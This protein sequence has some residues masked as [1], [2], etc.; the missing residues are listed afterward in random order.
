MDKGNN[1]APKTDRITNMYIAG[2][3]GEPR[4]GQSHRVLLK[5]QIPTCS[6][7]VNKVRLG[8]IVLYSFES[9]YKSLKNVSLQYPLY[10]H[11]VNVDEMSQ[12]R[13]ISSILQ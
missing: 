7:V 9:I 5:Q 12:L 8:D 4:D 11:G 13:T 10:L 6:F 1:L 2:F 3:K